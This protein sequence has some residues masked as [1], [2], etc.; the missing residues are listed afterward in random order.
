[1]SEFESLATEF[2]GK[3][4]SIHRKRRLSPD[5]A[6]VYGELSRRIASVEDFLGPRRERGDRVAV[7]LEIH[8]STSRLLRALAAAVWRWG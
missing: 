4:S 7:L 8:R 3:D 5:F 1:M 2:N 6:C